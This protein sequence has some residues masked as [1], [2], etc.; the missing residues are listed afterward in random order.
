MG[1]SCDIAVVLV[2][3]FF[4]A[5]ALIAGGAEVTDSCSG[6]GVAGMGFD[7]VTD[8]STGVLHR[9]GSH[10]PPFGG[11][12]LFFRITSVQPWS[13]LGCSGVLDR[14]CPGSFTLDCSLL[15]VAVVT[16]VSVVTVAAVVAAA[17]CWSFIG[18]NLAMCPSCLQPQ[19]HGRL[20]STP[21]IICLGVSSW[22]NG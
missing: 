20:P 18:Q 21:T 2:L 8:V 5:E 22:C 1:T 9:R 11:D 14:N 4:L 6:V 7:V 12:F 13:A 3:D 15:M 16:V 19:R 17:F 10:F